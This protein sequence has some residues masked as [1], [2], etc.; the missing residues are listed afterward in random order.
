M[1]RAGLQVEEQARNHGVLLTDSGRKRFFLVTRMDRQSNDPRNEAHRKRKSNRTPQNE[2]H[3]N[4]TFSEPALPRQIAIF[5]IAK[6]ADNR[7]YLLISSS[8]AFRH[9]EL[10]T[11]RYSD[12]RNTRSN[13]TCRYFYPFNNISIPSTSQ[14]SVPS[15]QLPM[16]GINLTVHR[17]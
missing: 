12:I 10:K 8:E 6:V 11:D 1:I 2:T 3:T 14:S 5:N 4:L 9:L 13:G 15:Y 7:K 16:A 17:I